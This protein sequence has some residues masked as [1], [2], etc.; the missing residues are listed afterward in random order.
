M[1]MD[2]LEH[3]DIDENML[4]ELKLE[5][6][7]EYKVAMETVRHLWMVVQNTSSFPWNKATM[8][9]FKLQLFIGV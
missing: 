2:Q 7:T 8:D 9:R 1:V 4:K 3:P 6:H 5:L